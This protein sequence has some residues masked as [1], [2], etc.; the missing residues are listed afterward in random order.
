[1]CLCARARALRGKRAILRPAIRA[2]VYVA[3]VRNYSFRITRTHARLRIAEPR[4]AF[5]A[6]YFHVH[7]A[8]NI[9]YTQRTY[10]QQPSSVIRHT[11]CNSRV[12]MLDLD[13]T[14]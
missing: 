13:R 1:M 12:Y 14:Y 5:V 3:C 11:T 2:C 7:G 6:R 9:T 8:R 4:R 10:T